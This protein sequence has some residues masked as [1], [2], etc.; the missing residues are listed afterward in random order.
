MDRMETIK[1]LLKEMKISDELTTQFTSNLDAF[2]V[3]TKE[4]TQ[5]QLQE[6]TDQTRPTLVMVVDD[7]VTVRK[8]TTRLLE[9]A[10]MNA[11]TK[12][13]SSMRT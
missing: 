7:S 13:S 9:R 3:E 1:N 4:S 11:I 12:L 6:E 5:K 2:I 8:V 10:G